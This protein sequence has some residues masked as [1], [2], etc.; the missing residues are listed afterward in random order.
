M[1]LETLLESQ[2]KDNS[3][4]SPLELDHFHFISRGKVER[5]LRVIRFQGEERVNTPYEIDVEVAAATSI[6]PFGMLEEQL[7]GQ[8]SSLIMTEP[9]DVPRVIHGV[10]T[11]YD[12]AGT[13]AVDQVRIRLRLSARI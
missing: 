12:V 4:V 13:H 3:P 11:S 9:G 2:V 7:L 8:P 1:S 6:D 5:Q 10:V